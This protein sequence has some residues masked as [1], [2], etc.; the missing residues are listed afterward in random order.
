[1]NEETNNINEPI[2]EEAQIHTEET[3]VCKYCGRELNSEFDFCT[4]CG[5]SRSETPI[6]V[7]R[8]QEEKKA[9]PVIK[10]KKRNP[11]D[12]ILFILSLT[13]FG[14]ALVFFFT[15]ML[16]WASAGSVGGSN[17][18]F[19]NLFGSSDMSVYIISFINVVAAYLT[20]IVFML[21]GIVFL[22]FRKRK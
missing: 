16:S 20:S 5:K 7:T 15:G 18:M 12:I 9:P 10:A 6:P 21:A 17:S 11:A 22:M 3:V 13:S 4:F 1:M 19:G 14:A 8:V 2:I